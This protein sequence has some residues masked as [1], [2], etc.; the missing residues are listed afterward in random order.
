MLKPRE[1]DVALKK[2]HF[3]SSVP[4]SLYTQISQNNKTSE[5]GVKR[6]DNFATVQSPCWEILNG[7]IQVEALMS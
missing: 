3:W 6:V 5:A 7:D 4:V 2:R 1:E